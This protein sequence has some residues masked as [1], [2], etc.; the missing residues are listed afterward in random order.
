MAKDYAQA[1]KEE[2]KIVNKHVLKYSML[3][4]TKN[5]SLLVK[6]GQISK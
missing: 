1:V 5:A 2:L 3:R 6:R 4:G